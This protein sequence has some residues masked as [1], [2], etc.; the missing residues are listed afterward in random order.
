LRALR[1]AAHSASSA[2][3][4]PIP[5]LMGEPDHFE[6]AYH[7]RAAEHIDEQQHEASGLAH[8]ITTSELLMGRSP[9]LHVC[10]TN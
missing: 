7:E 8:S 9:A 1:Q 10:A 3:G 2:S 4:L 6:R 5:P